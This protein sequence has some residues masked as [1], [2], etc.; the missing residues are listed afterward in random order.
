MTE[1]REITE[2]KIIEFL[3]ENGPSFLG[4]VVKELKLSYSKGLE[5]V[6]RLLNKGE[7]RHSDPP[8]QFEINSDS[9]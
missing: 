1:K 7:I 6:N 9:K 5:L 3:G 8:L 2:E 4:E